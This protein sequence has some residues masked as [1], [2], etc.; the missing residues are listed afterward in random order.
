MINFKIQNLKCLQVLSVLAS[1]HN[2][3]HVSISAV[4]MLPAAN[5][6]KLANPL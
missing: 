6:L 4:V 3:F 1:G 2:L 5:H